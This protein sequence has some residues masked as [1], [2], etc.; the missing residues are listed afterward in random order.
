MDSG[1]CVHCQIW[2]QHLGASDGDAT[3]F[4]LMMGFALTYHK[5]MQ[6]LPSFKELS[7]WFALRT[8]RHKI[9]LYQFQHDTF[10]ANHLI[11]IVSATVWCINGTGHKVI[12][13]NK[14]F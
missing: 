3:A 12:A 2:I 14:V 8:L 10:H 4:Y 9:L 6:G 11:L 5:I 1:S 7:K 13:S